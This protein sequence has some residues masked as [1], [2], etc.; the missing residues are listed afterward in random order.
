MG[1]R[2]LEMTID[3]KTSSAEAQRRL[4]AYSRMARSPKVE[5]H[6]FTRS[7]IPKFMQK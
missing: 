7:L 5:H 1:S 2:K 3:S 6:S 4:R